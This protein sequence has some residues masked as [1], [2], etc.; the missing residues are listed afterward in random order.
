M[1]AVWAIG[2]AI[3]TWGTWLA[4]R[5]LSTPPPHLDAPFALFPVTILKPLKGADS[6]L[7]QNLLSFFKLDYPQFELLFSVADVRDPAFDVAQDLIGKHPHV[8]ARLIVGDVKVGPNPK[9]NNMV[10]SYE[11]ARFDWL[12]ISDSNVRVA[13]DYLKRM[14]AYL[15]N[16]VGAVTSLVAGQNANDLGG[17]L[18]ASCL[19]TFYARGMALAFATNNP[20]VMGKSMMFRK[21]TAERFGG[22]T[23]L[24]RYLA[25]DY[26]AGEA[27][28]HLGLKALMTCDPI[29]QHIGNYSFK[30]FWQRHLRWGRIRKNQSPLTFWLEPLMGSFCS[31]LMGAYATHSLFGTSFAAFLALHLMLWSSCD[32][33]MMRRLGQKVDHLLPC[34]WFLREALVLPLWINIAAGNTVDWRGGKLK[35]N[36]NGILEA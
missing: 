7:K 12:L 13:P 33:L 2:L 14:V 36:T 26:M 11:Q 15:D 17:H 1:L 29:V 4:L 31:G 24:A 32:F 5:H 27:I 9:I 22:I 18:E 8:R 35:L 3:T 34:I 30:S 23:M 21:S 19:N 16:G 6:D 20:I 28:R 25:E 10:K